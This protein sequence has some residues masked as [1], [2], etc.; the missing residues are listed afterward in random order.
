MPLF[1]QLKEALFFAPLSV[2]GLTR[3]SSQWLE[4]YFISGVVVFSLFSVLLLTHQEEIKAVILAYLFPESWQNISERLANYLF[5][6]QAKVVISNLI[7]AGSLVM[8]SALLFPIKERYSAAFEKEAGFKNGLVTEFP[9]RDQILEEIKLFLFYL[10][11]QLIILWIGYYPYP[12]TTGLSITLSYLFLFFTFGVDFISPTLQRHKIKYSVILKALSRK[13]LLVLTFG[14]LYSLPLILLSQWIF[15]FQNLTIIEIASILFLVNIILL[16]LAVPAGTRIASCVLPEARQTTL[17]SRRSV[18]TGYSTLAVVLSIFLFLHLTLIAS[19]HH[20]SQ[21]LKAEY[22]IEWTTINLD[23]PSFSEFF[24]G[25]SSSKLSFD[26][27]IT[28]P[29]EFDIVIEQCQIFAMQKEI[30]IATV[31]LNGFKIAAGEQRKVTLQ[32]DSKTDTQ[33]LSSITGILDNWRI[34]VELQLL[35][36]ILMRFNVME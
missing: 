17:P 25:K 26:I 15:T 4:I 13:P 22:D 16:T 10:T 1:Q 6:S 7:L 18:I 23:I 24:N 11:A 9:L 14:F 34:D 33:Y 2:T 30:T 19:M 28:N 20:K 5:E 27:T 3:R 32:L 31:D 12:W 29:T 35:P 36:G 21:L 8:A